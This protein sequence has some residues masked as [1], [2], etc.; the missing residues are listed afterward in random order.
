MA[1][2]LCE[3]S[4]KMVSQL[5]VG[6]IISNTRKLPPRCLYFSRLLLIVVLYQNLNLPMG[7]NLKPTCRI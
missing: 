5:S 3:T 7:F 1:G 2:D 6:T 4:E